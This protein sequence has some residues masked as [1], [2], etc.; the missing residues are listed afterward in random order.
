M[1]QALYFSKEFDG[2]RNAAERAI[3]LNPMDGSTMEFVGH[4]IAFSGDW[5]YGCELGER[6]RA[7][8]PNHPVW[9]WALPFFNAYRNGDYVNARPFALKFFMPGFYIAHVLL[10]A[11]HGQ[12]GESE[13]AAK[14][15]RDLLALIPDPEV[16]KAQLDKW[17]Q[18]ELVEKLV[19]GLRKAGL[20]P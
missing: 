18:P 9:Y 5:E 7:L 1:A 4:L 16:I 2:F 15:V 14:A 6:A 10:A 19:D 3:A 8:N 20:N 11:V 12:L 13:P 17:Y